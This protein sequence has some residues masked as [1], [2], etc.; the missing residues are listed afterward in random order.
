MKIGGFLPH[1]GTSATKDNMIYFAKESEKR[2]LDSLW[3]LERM[4]FPLKPKT[5][6]VGTPDGH[7]PVEYQTVFD[8]IDLLSFVAAHTDRILLGTSVVDMLFHNPVTLGRR[9][10]TLDV[11]SGGRLI[12]GLGLGWSK[13]EYEAA[14]VPFEKKGSRADEFLQAMKQVWTSD[15]VEFSG[16]FYKIAASK[17]GPKPLQKPH[18]QILLGGFTP[19]TFERI[20]KFAD[21]WLGIANMPPQQ[22][23]QVLSGLKSAA[24]AAGKRAQICLL[25]FPYMTGQKA[26]EESRMPLT[27]TADQI[28]QDID[29][30]RKLGVDHMILAPNAFTP[31]GSDV[32]N[33][34]ETT[35]QL[36]SYAR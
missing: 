16:Q 27:G 29:R 4:L 23:E 2:G 18:P 13:D 10:A 22:L 11:L 33:L 15:T 28:G 19:K 5:P 25:A 1:I 6:Y 32:K 20:I 31:Q 12:A 35:V 9:L 34:L 30:I 14:N 24:S 26:P 7:L 3:V 36:A 21:G 17:V 8:P